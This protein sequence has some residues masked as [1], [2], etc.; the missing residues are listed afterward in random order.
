MNHRSKI[1][2]IKK[3]EAELR[4]LFQDLKKGI[5]EEN[6][7]VVSKLLIEGQND[8]AKSVI[9]KLEDLDDITLETNIDMLDVIERDYLTKHQVLDDVAY[10]QLKINNDKS[11]IKEMIE[12]VFSVQLKKKGFIIEEETTE[13]IKLLKNDQVLYFF[14]YDDSK[15]LI[16]ELKEKVKYTNILI[17]CPTLAVEKKA[18]NTINNWIENMDTEERDNMKKYL[19]INLTSNERLEKEV[20]NIKKIKIA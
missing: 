8:K 14:E 10:E 15:N 4:E 6:I 1:D 20:S 3:K 12:N 16:H 9:S 13:Y 17:G 11:Q 7:Q 19:S 2:T 5:K 18:E